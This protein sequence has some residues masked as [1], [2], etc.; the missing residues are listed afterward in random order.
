MAIRKSSISGTPSGNTASR[1]ANPEIGA[2]YNNGTLGVEEIYTSVGWVAKSAPAS[3]PINVVATNQGSGRAYNDGQASVAFSDGTGGGL[4]IDYTVTPSP[5]T[6]PSTFTGS[7]SPITVTGLQSSQQYTY[8]LQARN[9]FGTSLLSTASAGVTATTAPAAPTIDSVT[10]GNAQASVAFSAN[11]TGGSAITEFTV[12]SSPDG[13]TASGAS[14]PLTVTGL[15][16]DTAYT[17]TVTAT[18]DNG[19]SAASAASNSVTPIDGITVEYLVVAGGGGGGGAS[20]NGGTPGGGGGAGGF[21]TSIGGSALTLIASTNYQVTVGAGGSAGGSRSSGVNGS[22]SVFSTITSTGGG[23]GSGQA[24]TPNSGG[25]GGGACGGTGGAGNAG[26]FTPS[27]GNDG[28]DGDGGGGGGATAAGSNGV[29]SGGNR[30]GGAGTAS[31]IT[32]SSVTYAGGGGGGGHIA[33]G[34][35]TPGAGGAGGGAAGVDSGNAV[36]ATVNTGGGGGGGGA[37]NGG[38]S[39]PSAGG[40]GI[41]I[42][43]YSDSKTITIGAGLTG[44]TPTPAGGFKVTTITAGTGTVSFS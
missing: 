33:G 12:T 10:G 39:N 13:L 21:R 2:T 25:S 14:S 11:A 16:N 26:A 23:R 18:N 32:G 34:T 41:V 7:S 40:S 24:S 15:T 3:V 30:S 31:S 5:A 35:G 4:V 28:G 8:T 36:A 22:N 27:E 17:F 42:L 9:N 19:T 29:G 44:S 6:S 43:K 20:D 1:P 37:V 38:T